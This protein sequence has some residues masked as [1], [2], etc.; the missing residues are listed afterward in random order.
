MKLKTLEHKVEVCLKTNG[1][2]QTKE[3]PSDV[4]GICGYDIPLPC[5]YQA[6]YSCEYGNFGC[7]YIEPKEDKFP[8]DYF[9]SWKW[10]K[11]Y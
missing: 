10:I 9:E 3:N 8:E 6:I 11:F 2:K 4:F 5:K 7:I 1:L